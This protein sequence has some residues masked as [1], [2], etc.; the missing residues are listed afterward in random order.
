[1][2]KIAVRIL[3]EL[4][5]FN[6]SLPPYI[7]AAPS[8]DNFRVIYFTIVHMP[9]MDGEEYAA[10]KPFEKGVY[11]FV[12]TLANDW[13]FSP[14][15]LRSLTPNGRF[16]VNTTLC[17]EGTHYHRERHSPAMSISSYIVC[18][19]LFMQTR[20]PGL[21]GIFE[22]AEMRE[23][24]A[25]KSMEYNLEL[26]IFRELFADK[27]GGTHKKRKREE[28]VAA[29]PLPD[30]PSSSTAEVAESDPPPNAPEV[31]DVVRRMQPQKTTPV[32][33]PWAF[34]LTRTLIPPLATRPITPSQTEVL[35]MAAAASSMPADEFT[36]NAQNVSEDPFKD[37]WEAGCYMSHVGMNYLKMWDKYVVPKPPQTETPLVYKGKRKHLPHQNEVFP[38]L[39][40]LDKTKSS[41]RAGGALCDAPGLGKTSQIGAIMRTNRI[42]KTTLIVAKNS[43]W[44]HWKKEL[45]MHGI[46]K[47]EFEFCNPRAAG[48]LPKAKMLAI[49]RVV[50]DECHEKVSMKFVNNLINYSS[51]IVWIVTGTPTMKTL[52]VF[53]SLFMSQRDYT[54]HYNQKLIGGYVPPLW[55]KLAVVRSSKHVPIK[56]PLLTETNVRVNMTAAEQRIYMRIER[57]LFL[58]LLND[59]DFEGKGW[60]RLRPLFMLLLESIF[61]GNFTILAS[62]LEEVKVVDVESPAFDRLT[63][64]TLPPKDECME[65]IKQ[66]HRE[67][68]CPVCA[69]ELV[70]DKSV[71]F[72]KCGHVQCECCF[73][74][75]A[76]SRTPRCGL[77]CAASTL[78]DCYQVAKIRQLCEDDQ[79]ESEEVEEEKEAPPTES[80]NVL[81]NVSVADTPKGSYIVDL[82]GKAKIAK[83]HV[84]IVTRSMGVIHA[85]KRQFDGCS[86]MGEHTNQNMIDQILE[87]VS[88]QEVD[89][90]LVLIPR[91]SN[92]VNLQNFDHVVLC[93]P[94]ESQ[95]AER[96][97]ISRFMRMGSVRPTLV[98]R[99]ICR[100]TVDEFMFRAH[101]QDIK[102][103]GQSVFQA[104]AARHHH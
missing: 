85:L 5:E 31:P 83:E 7:L 63:T 1:M 18:L 4:H 100:G 75:M 9:V 6:K 50:I 22:S 54:I 41:I 97:I 91:F 20:E 25:K 14:P 57:K 93:E 64:N 33:I 43:L 82:V 37:V 77:P 8:P 34:E 51:I 10:A 16:T 53:Q 48:N 79:S 68:E 62:R 42:E 86:V 71:F 56:L 49:G 28:D 102:V 96:Q 67:K 30:D 26:D 32:A 39:V 101:Q 98:H 46:K 3:K 15:T 23:E 94:P 29:D 81:K 80:A 27:I 88:Q 13:P 47:D 52:F 72:W 12:L 59:L 44:G 58:V 40:H 69:K 21:G 38:F 24:H 36:R 73:N 70:A 2:S 89:V 104:I 90:L 92:G 45:A 103:T 11:L 66:I 35:F 61:A 99:L 95:A 19:S 84:A 17:I 55:F 76:A 74:E 65:R 60:R 78:A 87:K